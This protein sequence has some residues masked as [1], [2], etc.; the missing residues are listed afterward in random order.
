VSSNP[1]GDRP[2]PSIRP[3][4]I[5]VLVV[6]ALLALAAGW[7]LLSFFY[8][9]WPSP[10]WLPVIALVVLAFAEGFL[11]QN[12]SARVQRRPGALP[13]EPLAVARYVVLAKAS[14]LAA[15]IFGGYSAGLL[16]FFLFRPDEFARDAVPAAGGGVVASLLLVA[17][18][19]WLERSCRVPEQP[20]RDDDGEP[21][22]RRA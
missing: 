10:P 3:T 1:G 4:S 21:G 22:R 11:A 8:N 20:D 13:V 16:L 15:A 9:S 14:S 12:T 6:A 17:A 7:L 19:L 2:D 5:S 18:G